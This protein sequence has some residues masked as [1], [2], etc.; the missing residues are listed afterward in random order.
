MTD[1]NKKNKKFT[2][3]A[4]VN[5]AAFNAAISACNQLQSGSSKLFVEAVIYASTKGT[6]PLYEKI[7]EMK[8]PNW[9]NFKGA[10]SRAC[11]AGEGAWSLIISSASAD[12]IESAKSGDHDSRFSKIDEILENY[13]I[14]LRKAYSFAKNPAQQ[15]AQQPATQPATQPVTDGQPSVDSDDF[16][17]QLLL[18]IEKFAGSLPATELYDIL[19]VATDNMCKKL[20]KEEKQA[21]NQ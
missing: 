1:L 20:T 6:T 11:T 12:E 4:S 17:E 18:L 8:L 7:K 2:D 21:V 19:S 10:V 9:G 3:S 14:S 5:L 13:K 15:P 16:N